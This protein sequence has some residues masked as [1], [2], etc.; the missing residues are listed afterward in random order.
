MARR[1]VQTLRE[2]FDEKW[3]P[4]PNTGC[5]LWMAGGTTGHGYGAIRA[6]DKRRTLRAHR[7]A[8]ELY[9]G[10]IPEGLVIDH[11]CRVRSCVNPDHL[12]VVTMA[13]NATENS[14]SQSAKNKIKTHC[15]SG[16]EYSAGNTYQKN[17][18]TCRVC[19][20]CKR[21]RAPIATAKYRAKK[22]A[23]I[24]IGSYPD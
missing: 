6:S 5:W 10:P 15:P 7:V 18:E 12:R 11:L 1:K 13:V 19:R 20:A 14:D 4:E 22:R 3:I 24:G 17:K 21:L 8:W 2:R 23:I 9:R 16:H